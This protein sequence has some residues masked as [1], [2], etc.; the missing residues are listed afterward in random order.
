MNIRP[1]TPEDA[2]FL[3]TMLFEAARWNPDWPRESMEEVLEEPV[4][5]RYHEG[6]GRPGDGGVIA[7]V[8]GMPVGA[9]WYR[10]FTE[11]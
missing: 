11:A 10:Q 1:A 9:V 3:K 4:L 8:D 5:R 2:E 6:W 7:E